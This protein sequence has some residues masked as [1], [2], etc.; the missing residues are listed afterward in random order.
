MTRK[1]AKKT[2]LTQYLPSPSLSYVIKIWEVK[3]DHTPEANYNI[4]NAISL[5]GLTVTVCLPEL[6]PLSARL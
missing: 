6:K 5:A 4:G 3:N 1:N 2:K